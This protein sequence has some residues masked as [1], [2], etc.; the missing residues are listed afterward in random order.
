MKKLLLLTVMCVLGFCLNAQK[1][2]FSYNFDDGLMNGW[3][4]FQ[5]SSM[6]DGPNWAVSQENDTY[7]SG[8]NNTR[9]IFSM[10]IDGATYMPYY[11]DNYIMT[12][13]KYLITETSVL[14]WYAR[15]TYANGNYEYNDPY[16]VYISE[17]GETLTKVWGG[18][19]LGDNNDAP[20]YTESYTFDSEYVGKEVYICFYHYGSNGDAICIDNIVLSSENGDGVA[21][22]STSFNVY[23]NPVNNVLFVDTDE[24][25]EQ[26]TIYNL[27]G[28][29]VYNEVYSSNN[30]K[31]NVSELEAGVYIVKVRTENNEVVNRFVKK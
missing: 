7:Y 12:T 21:E 19:V 20:E 15:H 31:I 23:P 27:T 6:A 8:Y 4:T 10:S 17:D 14:S 26:V 30:V 28:S 11:C 22:F 18:Y 2:T 16:D 3:E 13:E 9:C 5:K 24:N 1:T 29:M 25:V